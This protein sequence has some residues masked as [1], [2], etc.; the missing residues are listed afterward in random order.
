MPGSWR[1][2]ITLLA[3]RCRWW[4]RPPAPHKPRFARAC[5][6]STCTAAI[7]P[8]WRA[9]VS[10]YNPQVLPPLRRALLDFQPDVVHAHNVHADLSYASLRVAHRL[11]FPTVL[12]LH[13]LMPI[14]YGKWTLGL[15]PVRCPDALPPNWRL[16]PLYNLRQNRGRYNP[17]RNSVIRSV[18]RHHVDRCIALSQDQAAVLAQ[19]L[20]LTNLVRVP[21]G[22]DPATFE[23]P[24]AQVAALRARYGLEGCTVI[25]FAGR[26][27]ALKGG[28]QLLQALDQL[29]PEFPQLRLLVLSAA[30]L[31][32]AALAACRHLR[33]EQVVQGGW[34]S[35]E[36]LAAAYHLAD[37]VVVPSLYLDNFPTVNLEAMACAKPLVVTCY[38]GSR[39]MVLDGETGYVVHPYDV[40]GW[41]GRLRQLLQ[42]ADLRAQL[43]AAGQARLQAHFTL[44][45]QV[46][47]I[48][49][50]FQEIR[51]SVR[52]KPTKD[53]TLVNGKDGQ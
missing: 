43:G 30:P 7:L 2:A 31:D 12:T 51:Q 52:Q 50:I 18:L 49:A 39:E 35:G 48:L 36:E 8:R 6:R 32:P 21:N 46:Q 22:I 17:L 23:T 1:W 38:G 15:D 42:D 29:V 27:S 5:R 40:P 11:G 13:D 34:L 20:R 26:L 41:V 14:V 9:W 3:T 4:P 25:L 28:A 19:H 16:P 53:V 37:V 47:K 44:A 10:L 45:Q 33:P 24:P